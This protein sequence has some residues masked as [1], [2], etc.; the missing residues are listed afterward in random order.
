MERRAAQALT[1]ATSGLV[2][3]LEIVAGRIV[4]PYVGISLESFTAIIGTVLAGIAAGAWIGGGLA[5]RLDPAALIGPTIAAGG[6]LSWLSI[7]I[8]RALG[9]SLGSSALATVVL[10]AAAFLLPAAVVSAVSPMIAKLALNSIDETGAVVG[11]LSAAG[12][13]GALAGTFLTGFVLVAWLPVTVI[14]F[15]IGAV[16]IVIGL[17]MMWWLRRSGPTLPGAAVAVVAGIALLSGGGICDHET[18]YY[19]V[20]IQSTADAPDQRSLWLDQLRHG[21]VDLDDPTHLDIRYVRLFADVVDAM[22]DGP[23]DALH[24][25]GAAFSVPRYVEATRPGSSQLVFEIDDELV[26]IAE[27]ELG[28][29]LGPDLQ[30]RVGDARLGFAELD[31]DTYELIIGD[32]FG[33]EAVPWHLTTSEVAAEIDRLLRPGGIY[34]VNIIDGPDG[35]FAAALMATL[36]EHFDHLGVIEPTDV[37]ESNRLFNRLLVVSD[38]PLPELDIASADGRFVNGDPWGDGRIL[39]DNFAPVDQL[40]G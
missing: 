23:I 7:P 16:L 8:V 38:A 32:A 9:P 21:F 31:T 2:L 15:A 4:A 12:T 1:F 25:G 13:A 36:G 6:V 30:A 34:A 28:L 3:V 10:V 20:R 33:S 19:C 26:G 11:G 27:Q 24:I 22:P 14:V 39:T 18:E 40:I 17:A 29:V 5:D 37:R 35:R